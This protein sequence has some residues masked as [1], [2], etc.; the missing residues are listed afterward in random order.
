MVVKTRVELSINTD[1]LI[2][3]LNYFSKNV[4]FGKMPAYLIM[5]FKT[6]QMLKQSSVF[7]TTLDDTGE[8][9]FYGITIAVSEGLE[10]YKIDLVG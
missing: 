4:G 8:I 3:D 10:D 6:L 5:N 9:R 2:H 7:N 1:R